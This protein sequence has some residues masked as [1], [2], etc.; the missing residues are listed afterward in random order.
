[1]RVLARGYAVAFTIDGR[2][3]RDGASVQVGDEI[4][5]RLER[6]TLD[7]RVQGIEEPGGES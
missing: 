7:C 3:V 4:A 2:V 6:G 5:V 1:M